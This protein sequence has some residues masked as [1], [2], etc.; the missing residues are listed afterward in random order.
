MSTATEKLGKKLNAVM[1]KLT[2]DLPNE[3]GIL[4]WRLGCTQDELGAALDKAGADGWRPNMERDNGDDVATELRVHAW[5]LR[6]MKARASRCACG[7][8]GTWDRTVSGTC[9]YQPA[10]WGGCSRRGG[11][12]TS[13]PFAGAEDVGKFV[14]AREAA[15]RLDISLDDLVDLAEEYSAAHYHQQK[16]ILA[17]YGF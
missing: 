2:G 1:K 4:R 14:A 11:S 16:A 8:G 12:A 7:C 10:I 15:E 5:V 9:G 3:Y 17:S 6:E 13:A